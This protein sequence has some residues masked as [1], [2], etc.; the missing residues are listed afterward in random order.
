MKME[1]SHTYLTLIWTRRS[2]LCATAFAATVKAECLAKAW[3]EMG[4]CVLK[5]C[6]MRWALIHHQFGSHTVSGN[7]VNSMV[8]ISSIININQ[9]FEN[10]GCLTLSFLSS[11]CNA[12]VTV[13]AT[14][15]T[16]SDD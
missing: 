13:S 12:T 2:R 6:V 1:A 8:L 7:R 10:E 4:Y 14:L 5:K 9:I 15:P 3:P 11:F 16:T